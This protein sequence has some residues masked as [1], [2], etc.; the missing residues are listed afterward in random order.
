MVRES[1]LEA[2]CNN[3]ESKRL[4][5]GSYYPFRYSDSKNPISVNFYR[6]GHYLEDKFVFKGTGG[7]EQ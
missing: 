5:L 7:E 6:R 1:A 3:T 4:F 2:L